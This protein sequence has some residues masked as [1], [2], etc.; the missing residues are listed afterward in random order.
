MFTASVSG[1]PY[2]SLAPEVDHPVK[3]FQTAPGRS[4]PET[5][6]RF[7]ANIDLRSLYALNRQAHGGV[8]MGIGSGR[9]QPNAPGAHSQRTQPKGRQPVDF[10]KRSPRGAGV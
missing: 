1:L 8:Y 3:Q 4:R 6:L 10:G 2:Q 9:T 5:R 7:R